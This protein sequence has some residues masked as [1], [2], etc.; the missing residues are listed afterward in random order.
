M[1]EE[2]ELSKTSLLNAIRDVIAH[3]DEYIKAMD[4]SEMSDSVKTIIELIKSVS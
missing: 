3:K 4:E 2:E 1:L